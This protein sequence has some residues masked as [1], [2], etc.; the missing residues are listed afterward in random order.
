MVR[1]IHGNTL[2]ALAEKVL[3]PI[4]LLKISTSTPILFWSGV[5]VLSWGG[6]TYE[7]VGGMARITSV[8]EQSLLQATGTVFELSGIPSYNLAQALGAQY[9]DK[10]AQLW[11]ALLQGRT[12]VM[13]VREDGDASTISVSA[14]NRLI[15]LE[16]TRVRYYTDRDQKELFPGDDGFEFVAAI[17][18]G[19]EFV[20]GK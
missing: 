17:N 13:S 2:S 1:Q 9:Q 18:D 8:R 12:D 14:E 4:L 3:R 6:D 7:G 5:G 16:R 11:L 10:I 19:S 20:W 15:D